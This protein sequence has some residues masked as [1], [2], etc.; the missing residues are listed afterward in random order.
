MKIMTRKEATALQ[1]TWLA[2]LAQRRPECTQWS[3]Q[4]IQA[5][6]LFEMAS[7][8]CWLGTRSQSYALRGLTAE[9]LLRKY[10]PEG[11]TSV[12]VAIMENGRDAIWAPS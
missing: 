7:L 11:L 8:S 10:D 9:Q 3:D 2:Q 4:E 5:L 1:N 6:F 12:T